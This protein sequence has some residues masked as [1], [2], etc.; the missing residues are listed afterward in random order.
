MDPLLKQAT[1]DADV[2]AALV[3]VVHIRLARTAF[4]DVLHRQSRHRAYPLVRLG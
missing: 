3:S 2:L 4:A 1:A